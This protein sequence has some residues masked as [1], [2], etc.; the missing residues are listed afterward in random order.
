[1]INVVSELCC[2]HFE[3]EELSAAINNEAKFVQPGLSIVLITMILVMGNY[4]LV[5]LWQGALLAQGFYIAFFCAYG[6]W[7]WRRF[8]VHH[9][10]KNT[11]RES[12]W[13]PSFRRGSVV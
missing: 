12:S 11:P 9:A 4:H 5:N 6:Y 3:L 10:R 13:E 2:H 8:H 7:T 1:L